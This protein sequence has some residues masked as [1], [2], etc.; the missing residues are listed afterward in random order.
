MVTRWIIQP[1]LLAWP[2]LGR[3]ICKMSRGREVVSHSNTGGSSCACMVAASYLAH[4]GRQCWGRPPGSVRSTASALPDHLALLGTFNI[5]ACSR[6]LLIQPVSRSFVMFRIRHFANLRV[7]RGLLI[8]LNCEPRSP[9]VNI[10][11]QLTDQRQEVIFVGEDDFSLG[12]AHIEVVRGGRA[13]YLQI[14][15]QFPGLRRLA[16]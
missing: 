2:R 1:T 12:W 11:E 8:P 13:I 4:P 5:L 15:K 3:C 14:Q 10:V 6:T 16:D 9:L 7:R